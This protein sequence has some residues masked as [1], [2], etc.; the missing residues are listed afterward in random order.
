MDD[1]EVK[2]VAKEHPHNKFSNVAGGSMTKTVMSLGFLKLKKES[3]D[4]Y[5]VEIV[6][7]D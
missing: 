5:L 7:W 4:T 6:I 3:N 2:V 1:D